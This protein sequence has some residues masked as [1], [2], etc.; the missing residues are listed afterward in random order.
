M[1]DY[2]NKVNVELIPFNYAPDPTKSWTWITAV[3]NIEKNEELFI[4]YGDK[5]D[6]EFFSTYGCIPQCTRPFNVIVLFDSNINFKNVSRE[7]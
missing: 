7:H 6:I 5:S 3:K 2:S 1:P 4:D